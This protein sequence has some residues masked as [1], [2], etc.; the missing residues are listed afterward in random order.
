MEA[1][2]KDASIKKSTIPDVH[3]YD[4]PIT[5]FEKL[6]KQ[7]TAKVVECVRE[8]LKNKTCDY[9]VIASTTGY[10][11]NSFKDVVKEL[12]IATILCKQ[13]LNDKL[14]MSSEAEKD[15]NMFA[16]I[17]DIPRG[18]LKDLIGDEAR[19]LLRSFSQGYKVCAELVLFLINNDKV[20]PGDS[21]VVIAGTVVGADTAI[22]VF[23]KKNNNFKVKRMISM[24]IN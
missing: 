19:G 16:K 14:F 18:Y 17:V 3:S 2:K 22:E 12:N 21:I 24:A 23:I 6:G 20:K 11:A 7:N 9:L 15:I 13:D 1:F 5:Y 4:A 10:T 8:F